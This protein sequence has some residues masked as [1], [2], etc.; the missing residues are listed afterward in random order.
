MKVKRCT[1]CGTEKPVKEF[2]KTKRSRDGRQSW[3]NECCRPIKKAWRERNKQK[4]ADYQ[5]R[6]LLE[7]PMMNLYKTMQNTAKRR[8]KQ[9]CHVTRLDLEKIWEDQKGICYWSGM[10]ME[11]VAGKWKNPMAVSV[12][13]LDTSK[14]YTVDNIVLCCS[15]ANFG[16]MQTPVDEWKKFLQKLGLRGLW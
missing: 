10:P 5:R 1:N 11:K 12:D 8:R 16:R 14:E 7:N 13:R 9:I 4:G 6:Y 3:C 2:G 15:W